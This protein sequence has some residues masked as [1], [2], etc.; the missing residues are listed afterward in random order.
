M[1]KKVPYTE[2]GCSF[3]F[4]I[5]AGYTEVDD[6]YPVVLRPHKRGLGLGLNL[7][8]GLNIDLGLWS[9]TRPQAI[10]NTLK[11]IIMSTTGL[12]GIFTIAKDI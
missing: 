4:S 7:S 5:I 6:F 1:S 9:Q 10:S 8:F 2:F 12:C 11:M 3:V